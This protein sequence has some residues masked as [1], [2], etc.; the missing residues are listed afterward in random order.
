[1]FT[2]HR[3]CDIERELKPEDFP[4][5]CSPTHALEQSKIHYD[6]DKRSYRSDFKPFFDVPE[7]LYSRNPTWR[8]SQ[9]GYA[10]QKHGNRVGSIFPPAKGNAVA[11]NGQGREIVDNILNDTGK[12]V[13]QSNTGRFGQV[14]DIIA[15]DGRGLRYDLN[16]KLIGFLEPPK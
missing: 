10:L 3:G 14:T 2:L 5:I 4:Y 16:G 13:L 6:L 12:T 1:M 15:T 11:I 7:R 8:R 9:A